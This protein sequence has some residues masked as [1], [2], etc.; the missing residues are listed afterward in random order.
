MTAFPWLRPNFSG[1][2]VFLV[3]PAFLMAFASWRTRLGAVACGTAVLIMLPNWA[4]GTWGLYQFGFRFL[5]DAMP[6]LLVALAVAYRER[7]TPALLGA[8]LLSAAVNAYGLWADAASFFGDPP[9]I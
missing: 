7:V 8:V 5:L 3:A 1:L 2:S 4:H 9:L 6:V